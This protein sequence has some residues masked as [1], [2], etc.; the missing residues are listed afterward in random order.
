MHCYW[1]SQSI[2]CS[3]VPDSLWP[4]GLQCSVHGI[5]QARILQWRAKTHLIGNPFGHLL[6]AIV[7]NQMARLGDLKSFFQPLSRV[8]TL[9]TTFLIYGHSRWHT[10]IWQHPRG[11]RRRSLR[12]L[13]SSPSHAA[14]LADGPVVKNLP[15]M[16]ADTSS[17]PDLGRPHM[18]WGHLSLLSGACAPQWE[19]PRQW[20]APSPQLE[21]SPCS[22]ED[23]AQSRINKHITKT[24]KLDSPLSYSVWRSDGLCVSRLFLLPSTSGLWRRVVLWGSTACC[25]MTPYRRPAATKRC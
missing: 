5:P 4:H 7:F 13:S 23:P 15:T 24:L 19:T 12:V 11:G 10:V 18:S 6:T 3:V 8:L 1:R 14:G 17:V 25:L 16:P 9:S 21:N 2:S 22:Y 20:E